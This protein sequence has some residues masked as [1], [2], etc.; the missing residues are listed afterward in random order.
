MNHH[1]AWTLILLMGLAVGACGSGDDPAAP[2]GDDGSDA[3]VVTSDPSFAQDVQEIFNRTG[4]A[5]SS[6]HGSVTAGSLDLRTGSAYA[7]LV[8]ASAVGEPGLIRVIPGSADDSYLVV[9]LEGRQSAGQ[10]MPLGS[11]PLD[12]IDL[13]NIKNWINQGAQNDP[14]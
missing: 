1:A 2:D 11:S 10:A 4:C 6:C 3:R 8:E 5:T 12:D 7:Q 14:F 9:K 13:S